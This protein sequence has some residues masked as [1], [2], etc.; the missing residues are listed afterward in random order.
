VGADWV[1]VHVESCLHLDRTLALARELGMKA[2]AALN[3]AT[4]PTVLEYV[5]DRL[6]FVLL[7][8]VNPGFAG[9]TMVP[10]GLRKI[11]DTRAWLDAHGCGHLPIEVDGN[12]SLAN[13]PGMVAA[14]ADVLV[15]GTSS[16][17]APGRLAD[18]VAATRAAIGRGLANRAPS[19][20]E[21]AA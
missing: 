17:F 13:I 14:G 10:G 21:A 7:M 6:D 20:D 15:A 12:V 3:P 16:V 11:A 8:T 9:Q 19:T 4:P 5:L 2:G 18:N 1:S